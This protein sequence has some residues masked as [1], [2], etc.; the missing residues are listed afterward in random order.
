M[1]PASVLAPA[2]GAPAGADRLTTAGAETPGDAAAPDAVSAGDA[3]PP[4]PSNACACAPQRPPAAAIATKT[5]P[6][7]RMWLIPFFSCFDV[8]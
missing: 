1:P 6:I 3:A 7:P 8:L 2:A 4:L 5:R